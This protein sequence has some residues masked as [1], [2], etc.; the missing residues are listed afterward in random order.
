MCTTFTEKKSGIG[1]NCYWLRMPVHNSYKILEIIEDNLLLKPKLTY[2][3]ECNIKPHTY[4]WLDRGDI[5]Y[6]A[7]LQQN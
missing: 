1:E 2:Y 4:L 3:N 5:W 7:V 6:L